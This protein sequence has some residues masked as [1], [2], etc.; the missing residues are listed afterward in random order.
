MPAIGTFRL[1]KIGMASTIHLL[2]LQIEGEDCDV[3]V[4]D[5]VNSSILPRCSAFGSEACTQGR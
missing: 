4:E 2:S 5:V 1:Y 3:L